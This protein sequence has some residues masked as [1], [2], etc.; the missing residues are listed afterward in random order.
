MNEAEMA[1]WMKYASPNENHEF[2]K[3]LL[4]TLV[5]AF[6]SWGHTPLSAYVPSFK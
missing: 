3:K 2:L 6:A 1:A 4:S 5:S